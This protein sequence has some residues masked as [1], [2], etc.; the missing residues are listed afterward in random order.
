M[1]RSIV[2]GIALVLCLCGLAYAQQ[3]TGGDTK[4]RTIAITYPPKGRVRVLLA[5]TTRAPRFNGA[6]EI[7][8]LRGQTQVEIELDDM[9]PAYLLG[10]DYSTFVM[11]AITPEGQ[12]ENMGEFRLAGSR[13]K[14]RVTTRYETFSLMVT[15]EPHYAVQKPSRL[16]VLENVPPKGAVAI[17]SAD[18]Y[19]TGDSG[20]YFS[21]TQ[22]PETVTKDYAKQPIEL[23]GARLA[24]KI[25]ELAR[26]EEFARKDLSAARD[27]LAKAEQYYLGADRPSAELLARKAI[28]EA[29]AAR[30]L[31]EDKAE[32]K[33]IRDTIRERE[34]VIADR[35]RELQGYL[36]TIDD[37]KSEIR[38]SEAARQRAED[39][40]ER[41]HEESAELRLRNR[42]LQSQV[43]QMNEQIGDLESRLGMVERERETERQSLEREQAYLSLKDKLG[44]LATIQNDPRGFKVILPDALFV[45]AKSDLKQNAAVKLNPI[46]GVLL[47]HP[48]IQ[49]LIEGY[50]DDRGQMDAL[51]QLSQLRAQ[52]IADFFATGGIAPARFK[53]TGYGSANPITSNKNLSGRTANRR[54]ELVFIKP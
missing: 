46:I 53:V 28:R 4:R 14:L 31:A 39:E 51:L 10:A 1:I 20:R 49:F 41:A 25:A 42:A 2:A 34:E 40:A 45:T 48:S 19:F 24:V 6:A 43:D 54:V 50:T 38:V 47:G 12:V 27:S 15:A 52:S 7:Q 11:W 32:Q 3:S 9:S 23:L 13:S 26:A 35:E 5:G 17:Q 33:R 29:E 22:L 18:V 30:E 16:V 36:D 37:L 8:R 44:P 21:D